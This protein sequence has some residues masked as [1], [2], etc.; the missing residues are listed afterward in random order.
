MNNPDPSD[1]SAKLR[2]WTVEPHM[3]GSFSRKVWQRIAARQAEREEAFWP[4]V[5]QW[6]SARLVRPQYAAALFAITLSASIGLAHLQAQG[7]NAKHWKTLEA[8]YA[9]SVDPL[10]M[11][12]Q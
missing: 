5:A 12:G 6:F 1:L 10:A 3:P 8:R 2:T 11:M 7:A 9:A 4:K